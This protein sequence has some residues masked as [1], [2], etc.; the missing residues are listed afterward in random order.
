MKIKKK[1]VTV[2]FILFL[3]SCT[4]SRPEI[5]KAQIFPL[6]NYSQNIQRF[7]NPNSPDYNIPL[8]SNNVIL[9]KENAYKEHF[10]GE[11]S[12]WSDSFVSGILNKQNTD[13][14]YSVEKFL[15]QKYRE[16]CDT[17][18]PKSFATNLK[19]YTCDW[20]DN[21]ILRN[22]DLNQF[23]QKL[24]FYKNNRAIATNN[25]SAR[26][27]PTN[28]PLFYDYRL[29]GE[30]YPFDMLQVSSIWVGTPLYIVGKSKDKEWSL[31]LTNSGF[32]TWVPSNKIALASEK[33]IF[34]YQENVKKHGLRVVTQPHS[35]IINNS[36][37]IELRA[38]T[39]S[40]FP[41]QQQEET[42]KVFFPI[43]LENGYAKFITAKINEDKVS[44][45]PLSSSPKN[46]VNV[47]QPLLGRPYGWGGLYYYNDCSQELR[48]IFSVFG[49]WLPRNSAYQYQ[50][51]KMIDLSNY[52]TQERL[53]ALSKLGRKFVTLVY[54]KGHIMLY[55]GNF[56]NAPLVHN[57]IW[58]LKP[59]DN[60]YRSIIGQS[61]LIPLLSS[62]PENPELISIADDKYRPKFIITYLDEL[63]NN[64]DSVAKVLK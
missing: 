49:I 42:N 17:D 57:N 30:G 22:M 3:Q 29:A 6:N 37:K 14:I 26:T 58:G 10:F 52:S 36:G 20:F 13:S 32:V 48:N 34:E 45:F 24:F 53:E 19:P 51:G 59:A 2:S 64:G 12:P 39:G 46:F 4:T 60:S 55:I 11:Q 44:I 8:I 62:Y 61:S 1:L 38:Y 21:Q 40:L 23:E 7:I 47:I 5:N 41:G 15:F 63:P 9:E 27:F 16:N 50:E 28:S 35:P 31:V 56:N 18:N 54:I 33:F 43:S 25:I